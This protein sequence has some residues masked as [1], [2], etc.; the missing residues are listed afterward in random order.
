MVDRAC[1]KLSIARQVE[2]LGLSRSTFYYAPRGESAE[3]LALMRRIDELFLECPFGA[4]PG[5]DPGGRA[6]WCGL[7]R[8]RGA[9][10]PA[11]G[12]GV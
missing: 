5:L 10:S 2:L 12:C 1:G 6:R 9:S 3:N 4:C 7:W 11:A 8:E